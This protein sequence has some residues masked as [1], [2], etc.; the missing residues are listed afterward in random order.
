M[1]NILLRI[2]CGCDEDN[3]VSMADVSL[4]LL[5]HQYYDVFVFEKK[6]KGVWESIR[7]IFVGV[8]RDSALKKKHMIKI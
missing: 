5:Q 7:G 1:T 3:N 2:D 6:A 8:I 4:S